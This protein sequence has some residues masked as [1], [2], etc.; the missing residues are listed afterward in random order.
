MRDEH[1]KNNVSN[2]VKNEEKRIKRGKNKTRTRIEEKKVKPSY[3]ERNQDIAVTARRLTGGWRASGL[4][5]A[6]LTY[7]SKSNLYWMARNTLAG[8]LSV[9]LCVVLRPGCVRG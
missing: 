6:S 9:C 8:R 1:R 3:E 7:S 4:N 2:R 5:V